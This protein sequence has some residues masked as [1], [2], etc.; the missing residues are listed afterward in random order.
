MEFT[1]A[2]AKSHAPR[3]RATLQSRKQPTPDIRPPRQ[4]ETGEK[5]KPAPSRTQATAFFLALRRLE[6]KGLLTS[7]LGEATPQ[8]GGRAKRYWALT[9]EGLSS[10][11]TALDNADRMREGLDP[12]LQP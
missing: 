6:R 8:R 5:T 3:N 9:D 12:V 1:A 4:E 10:L 2:T 11:R 7:T